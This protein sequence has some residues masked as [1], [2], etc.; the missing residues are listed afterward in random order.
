MKVIIICTVVSLFDLSIIDQI[1]RCKWYCL[2]IGA[3]IMF[4]IKYFGYI[5]KKKIKSN[6]F[7]KML[8]KIDA[9]V[10]YDV[11]HLSISIT[12]L[13]T[14]INNNRFININLYF[15]KNNLFF[16][17][18]CPHFNIV[19]KGNKK[20]IRKKLIKILNILLCINSKKNRK[21]L[22]NYV[23]N[24]FNSIKSLLYV[25]NLDNIWVKKMLRLFTLQKNFYNV[26]SY[27][28]LINCIIKLNSNTSMNE[29]N[30]NFKSLVI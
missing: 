8:K 15:V 27:K 23:L 14:L 22:I 16:D 3:K 29:I 7:K 25:I 24:N 28:E 26:L 20:I 17:G 18:I 1:K 5:D 2:N 10:F 30:N 9:L 19:I 11:N 4:K 13:Y 21:F 12:S 6:N